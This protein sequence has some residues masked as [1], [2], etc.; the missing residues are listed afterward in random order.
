MPTCGTSITI[1]KFWVQKYKFISTFQHI[2]AKNYQQ[3]IVED[4][5]TYLINIY[6]DTDIDIIFIKEN[7]DK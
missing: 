4:K 6:D 5:H 3:K 7:V 2:I 1:L